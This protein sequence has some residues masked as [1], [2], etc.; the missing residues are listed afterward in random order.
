MPGLRELPSQRAFSA[1][2]SATSA[3]P[4]T[5]MVK[6]EVPDISATHT[7]P[8]QAIDHAMRAVEA[9]LAKPDFWVPIG[10]N[11]I[12]LGLVRDLPYMAHETHLPGTQILVNRNYKPLGN[13][14]RP[15]EG[16]ADYEQQ[17][18]LHVRLSPVQ[19]A[20]VAS[21]LKALALFSDKDAPWQGREEAAAYLE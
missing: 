14:A 6:I 16:W 12:Y 3:T 15:D 20:E 17:L 9:H 2:T 13:N 8:L 18:N 21:P 1:A 10:E 7:S 4:A 11:A 5:P 19:I